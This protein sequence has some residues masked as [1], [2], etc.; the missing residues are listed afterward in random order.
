MKL[1]KQEQ[2]QKIKPKAHTQILHLLALPHNFKFISSTRA[3]DEKASP[4]AVPSMS[5]LS[6][7]AAGPG[8][9]AVCARTGTL[10]VLQPVR[11]AGS[12]GILTQRGTLESFMAR[13]WKSVRS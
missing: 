1:K 10:P 6:A 2:Q 4:H 13:L 11:A 3:R 12:V 7:P 5:R 9:G 8:L